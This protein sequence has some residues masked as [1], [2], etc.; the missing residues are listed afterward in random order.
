[1][2]FLSG[3]GGFFGRIFGSPENTGKTLDMIKNGL[4]AVVL[5]QEEKIQY[6]QKAVE[7]YLEFVKMANS[8][9]DIAR[10]FIAILISIFWSL[11]LFGCFFLATAGI[12]SAQAAAASVVLFDMTF[13]LVLP[14]WGAVMVFYFGKGILENRAKE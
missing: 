12:W 7:L 9:P 3:V 8:G 10:R 14:S 5:T 6:S 2:K 4:D 11:A 1:M 13:K